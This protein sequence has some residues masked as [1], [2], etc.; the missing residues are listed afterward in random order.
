MW[1]VAEEPPSVEV[2]PSEIEAFDSWAVATPQIEAVPAEAPVEEE[3]ELGTTAPDASAETAAPSGFDWEAILSPALAVPQPAAEEAV[4]EPAAE[5]ISLAETVQEAPAETLQ[6]A[7]WTVESA[8][9][10]MT[11]ASVAETP[12]L[13]APTAEAPVPEAPTAETPE[14]LASPQPAA[15]STGWAWD[16]DAAPVAEAPAEA[17]EESPLVELP[18]SEPAPAHE[19][20]RSEL[21]VPEAEVSSPTSDTIDEW[22]DTGW[23]EPDVEVPGSHSAVAELPVA[24]PPVVELPVEEGESRLVEAPFTE[25]SVMDTPMVEAPMEVQFEAPVEEM[26]TI[27]AP[28]VEAMVE[29]APPAQVAPLDDLKARIEETRRRIRQE[30]EQPFVSPVVASPV[31][32][33]WTVAPVLPT[34]SAAP[35]P[36]PT[37]FASA[38][39]EPQPA[40]VAAVEPLVLA[41]EPVVSDEPEAEEEPVDYDSMRSRIEVTRSR[42]K[43]KAFDAM[44]TGEAALLGRDTEDAEHRRKVASPVDSEVND[45]IETSLREELD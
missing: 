27:E 29:T 41:E 15:K 19:A 18:V 30:L 10:W 33:D 32:D 35:E 4:G 37:P 11:A 38:A 12:E 44:M 28:P 6:P 45:T 8:E 43:A 16:F 1:P 24:E 5:D 34:A 23:S 25:S 39:P 31:E 26:S 9:D 17:R 20:E 3:P 21:T 22:P 40:P 7:A 42:L 14:V 36:Q 13:E 2:A